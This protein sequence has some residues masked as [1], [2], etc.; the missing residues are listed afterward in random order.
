MQTLSKITTKKV[1]LMNEIDKLSISKPEKGLILALVNDLIN[2]VIL[3]ENQI[4]S[5]V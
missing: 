1:G 3:N 4:I 2:D 5:E